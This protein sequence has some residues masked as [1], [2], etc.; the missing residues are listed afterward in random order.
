VDDQRTRRP[1]STHAGRWR[2]G[3]RVQSRSLARCL[4]DAWTFRRPLDESPVAVR[5]DATT[6]V[7][8]QRYVVARTARELRE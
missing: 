1:V 5:G 7:E 8:L 6:V 4:A 3:G 2:P